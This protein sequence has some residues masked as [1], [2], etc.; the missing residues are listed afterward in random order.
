MAREQS[1]PGTEGPQ[2]RSP[3]FPRN[4]HP[5]HLDLPSFPGLPHAPPAASP[6]PARR[7]PGHHGLCP[8]VLWAG[9]SGSA[10]PASQQA[11]RL[12]S[13]SMAPSTPPR[14]TPDLS[15]FLYNFQV[16]FFSWPP[17]QGNNHKPPFAG[18]DIE[19]TCPAVNKDTPGPWLKARCLSSA[20]SLQGTQTLHLLPSWQ[21]APSPWGLAS[22]TNSPATQSPRVPFSGFG[23]T[24]PAGFLPH[25][26][27]P[28]QQSALS[29]SPPRPH[30]GLSL[31]PG[32]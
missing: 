7:S 4:D 12:L 14:I 11:P 28:G 29:Q 17:L 1:P 21:N 30:S 10:P 18:E 26:L 31:C 16:T 22:L 24:G 5:H 32:Q 23:S 27:P 25:Q 20:T 19:V 8:T 9:C 15:M 6:G 3:V 13:P 2:S